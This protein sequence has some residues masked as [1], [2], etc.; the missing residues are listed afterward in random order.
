MLRVQG[1]DR[2]LGKQMLPLDD[3]KVWVEH[4]SQKTCQCLWGL[5]YRLTHLSNKRTN[6]NCQL[7]GQ[8]VST[9]NTTQ[10]T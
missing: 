5:G 3:K 4:L 6:S 8:A 9:L 7:V 1:C 2:P 10:G